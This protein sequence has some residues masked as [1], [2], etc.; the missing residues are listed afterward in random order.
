M[1][2]WD[3]D[4]DNKNGDIFIDAPRFL[5][6]VRSMDNNLNEEEA[7]Q[8]AKSLPRGKR[9]AVPGCYCVRCVRPCSFP[10]AVTYNCTEN[11]TFLPCISLPFGC[12]VCINGS[13]ADG[14]YTNI[15]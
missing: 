4:N 6:M 1:Q 14:F 2:K 9:E 3:H 10:V 11:W 5:S 15:K 7:K 8:Y 13:D 12:C